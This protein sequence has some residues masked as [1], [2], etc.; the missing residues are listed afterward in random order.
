MSEHRKTLLSRFLQ[1]VWS[2]GDIDAVDRYIADAYSIRHDPGDRWEGQ[3]LDLA[4]FK[5]RLRLSRAPFPDQRFVVQAMIAEGNAI[6]A[7]WHWMATHLG[8]FPGFPATGKPLRMS[9]MTV[10]DFDA[11]DRLTGHWQVADRL[12][13]YQQLQRDRAP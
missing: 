6:A 1:Y 10:Y 9:G 5:N 13:I 2:E 8:D 12:G 4:G 3:T 11:A 7:T